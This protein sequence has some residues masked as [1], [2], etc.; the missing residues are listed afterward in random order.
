MCDTKIN[1]FNDFDLSIS[2]DKVDAQ[3]YNILYHPT[4]YSLYPFDQKNNLQPSD[5]YFVG[6]AK[7]RLDEIIESYEKLTDMGFSCD[8][9][10]TDVDPKDQKYSKDIHYNCRL[11]YEENLERIKNSQ[12]IST[13]GLMYFIIF[14]SVSTRFET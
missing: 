11:T 4:P 10:I 13:S 3:K 5:V 14:L 2:Y 12:T 6:R 8:F 7:N 1:D 9:H